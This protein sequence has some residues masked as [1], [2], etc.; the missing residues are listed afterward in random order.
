MSIIE[1]TG[2]ATIMAMHDGTLHYQRR[3]WLRPTLRLPF[4]IEV[5]L[6]AVPVVD[7]TS[8]RKIVPESVS[9]YLHI[10]H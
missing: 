6:V 2:P 3:G 9:K 5:K 10:Q 8:K 7:R 4:I 1:G